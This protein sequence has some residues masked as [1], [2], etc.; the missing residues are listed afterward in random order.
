ML[1]KNGESQ[2][3]EIGT[4]IALLCNEVSPGGSPLR[5]K[6][7]MTLG[8]MTA[9]LFVVSVLCVV[10]LS[11]A[12]SSGAATIPV[13]TGSSYGPLSTD[14][15]TCVGNIVNFLNTSTLNNCEQDVSG[16]FTVGTNT[17]TGNEF[18]F[19]DGSGTQ[20]GIFDVLQL[21]GNSSITLALANFALPTGVFMC[22][23]GSDGPSTSVAHDSTNTPTGQLTDL[24]CTTGSTMFQ[25]V[26]DFTGEIDATFTL[27]G[28]TFTNL[29]DSP[30]AVFT[31]DGN[32]LG[33][34]FT[35]GVTVVATPEPG[36]LMLLGTGI[37]ALVGLR[38]R[39]Q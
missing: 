14:F 39:K 19:L 18:A 27:N 33:A 1:Q 8:R 13:R 5:G 21:T 28:V 12:S 38:R 30:V 36:T 22:G 26:L 16:T 25:N 9:R 2:E 32:I 31:T 20:F 35:P 37:A 17:Y 15:G 6:K 23:V 3:K 10:M 29:G 34:T 11:I 7:K 24:A 4:I